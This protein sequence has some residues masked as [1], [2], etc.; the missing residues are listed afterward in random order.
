MPSWTR[1]RCSLVSLT[2]EERDCSPSLTEIPFSALASKTTSPELLSQLLDCAGKGSFI[3]LSLLF[4]ISTKP[5][6][7]SLVWK[8][9]PCC[10]PL[11]GRTRFWLLTSPPWEATSFRHSPFFS[12]Y[13]IES[14]FLCK[15]PAPL[16]LEGS[17]RF[18]LIF[19]LKLLS[20]A[21]GR[22]ERSRAEAAVYAEGWLF[23]FWSL[24]ILFTNRVCLLGAI[25]TFF[26]FF[27]TQLTFCKQIT[28]GLADSLE[29]KVL[30]REMER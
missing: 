25:L 2:L 20:S 7:D 18:F 12:A 8:S 13:I 30:L 16:M 23:S 21:A 14:D 19:M 3:L 9:R 17:A 27:S 1:G 6:K 4:R 11:F 26:F 29:A 22:G 28:K 24:W 5:P 10:P 15:I